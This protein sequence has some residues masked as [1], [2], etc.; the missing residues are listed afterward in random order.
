ELQV[1]CADF[2]FWQQEWL[3]AAAA[4]QVNY[5]HKKL[6]G[7]LPVLSWPVKLR[8][9]TR[10]FRGCIQNFSFP[11]LPSDRLKDLSRRLNTT[12]FLVLLTGLATVL[13][14]YTN[15]EEVVLGTLSPS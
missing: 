2:A 9:V 5:W 13:H 1:Q 4:K 6:D 3:S 15:H 10:T 14:R 12:L 8:P 11:S 7:E